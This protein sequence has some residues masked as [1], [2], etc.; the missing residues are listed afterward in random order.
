MTK[1]KEKKSKTE[2]IKQ[3]LIYVYLPSE[4]MLN[5]WKELSTKSGLSMSKFVIEHVNNSLHQEDNKDGYASRAIMLDEIKNLK[6]ES[7]KKSKTI[8][9][10]DTL[11]ERLEK[12]VRDYRSKPFLTEDYTGVRQYEKEL[13]ELLRDRREVRK[14][15]ILEHLGIS[16]LDS[17]T[18]K[19]IMRQME[20]LE[21]Y[22][23]VK[24]IGSFWRWKG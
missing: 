11:V 10:L 1:N 8:K 20:N 24:D 12:E 22:G 19:S 6:D 16:P 13:I 21:R 4:D 2:T 9:M 18:V 3:R 17:N 5:Q 7:K 14:E 15:E 23:L